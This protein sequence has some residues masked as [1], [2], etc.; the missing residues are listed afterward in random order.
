[1]FLIVVKVISG[2]F[3]SDEEDQEDHRLNMSI[4][5]SIHEPNNSTLGLESD[6]GED[7]ESA[8]AMSSS[9]ASTSRAS[10]Y[11]PVS[12]FERGVCILRRLCGIQ[13]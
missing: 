6:D 5:T 11:V 9:F 2:S 8:D 3:F 1:M 12:Y 4:G 13:L 7:D 10:M